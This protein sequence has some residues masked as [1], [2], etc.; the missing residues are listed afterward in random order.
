MAGGWAPG[1]ELCLELP[2]A[3]LLARKLLPSSVTWGSLLTVRAHAE[4]LSAEGVEHGKP[5]E[6]GIFEWG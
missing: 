1:S 5:H 2:T 4:L 6:A 3:L